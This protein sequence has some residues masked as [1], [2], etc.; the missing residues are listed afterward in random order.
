MTEFG[1][2][3]N[4]KHK[5]YTVCESG[6]LRRAMHIPTCPEASI[7]AVCEECFMQLPSIEIVAIA[8][9][10]YRD[11]QNSCGTPEAGALLMSP[12]EH[13]LVESAIRA[14]VKYMKGETNERPFT[15]EALALN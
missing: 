3:G 11:T 1:S 7:M 5:W 13:L 15:Q 4:C 14:W 9:R 2:C 8:I 10:T 12:T 6:K